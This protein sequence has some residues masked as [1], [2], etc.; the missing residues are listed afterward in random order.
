MDAAV[1]FAEEIADDTV[2]LVSPVL[3]AMLSVWAGSL[4]D[5]GDMT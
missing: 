3:L 1:I 5:L 2:V 4:E